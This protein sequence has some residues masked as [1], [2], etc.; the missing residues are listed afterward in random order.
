M[1]KSI[2]PLM[3]GIAAMRAAYSRLGHRVRRDPSVKSHY[4]ELGNFLDALDTMQR[5][6]EWQRVYDATYQERYDQLV[7]ELKPA[8]AK[9]R[10]HLYAKA[11]V[12]KRFNKAD[13]TV[14]D[15]IVT[16]KAK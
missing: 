11:E 8:Q 9:H 10:A 5:H 1:S 4:G 12:C 16:A 15:A 6:R 2:A 7:H 13:R 3:R 14:R